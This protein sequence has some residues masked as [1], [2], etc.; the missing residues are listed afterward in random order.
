MTGHDAIVISLKRNEQDEMN[1]YTKMAISN[2]SEITGMTEAE[3]VKKMESDEV[4]RKAIEQ[5]AEAF[6]AA[7]PNKPYDKSGTIIMTEV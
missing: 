5:A 1:T 6:E 7:D 4:A 2:L 3:I